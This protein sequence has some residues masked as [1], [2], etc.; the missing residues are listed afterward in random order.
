MRWPTVLVVVLVCALALAGC[1][2]PA[3]RRPGTR[4]SGE[5]VEAL[6]HDW[7]FSDEYREVALEV[8][9]PWLLPHSVTI[10]CAALGDR[11]WIGA[12]DP[13]AKRWPSLVSRRPEVRLKIGERVYVARLREVD[14]FEEVRQARE[15]YAEKYGSPNPPPPGAPPIRYWRVERR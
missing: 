8:R 15:A 1:F 11:L 13:D 3:D 7:S 12:R 9:T 10:L 14:D 6:P 5:V 2:E 4:L